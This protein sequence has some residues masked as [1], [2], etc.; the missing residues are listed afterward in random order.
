MTRK[1][2]DITYALTRSTRKTVAIAV[3][4][5]GQVVVRAPEALSDRQMEAVIERKR[6]WIYRHLAQC[7]DLNAAR[8]AR[9][10]VNG[11]GFYILAARTG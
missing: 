3:E 10:Y 6:G 11:E 1:Y 2:K 9:G 7:H 5:N 8:A 4:R